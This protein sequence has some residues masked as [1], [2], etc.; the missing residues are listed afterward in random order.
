MI[1]YSNITLKTVLEM[2][3]K[4]ATQNMKNKYK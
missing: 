1:S 4:I 3:K 2:K